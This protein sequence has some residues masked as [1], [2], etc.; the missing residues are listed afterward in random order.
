LLI[1]IIVIRVVELLLQDLPLELLLLILVVVLLLQ[2][3]L[4]LLLNM[5]AEE[6]PINH[7]IIYAFSINCW[8]AS[9]LLL[10]LLHHRP[11]CFDDLKWFLIDIWNHI[12]EVAVI[13]MIASC[14][15]VPELPSWAGLFI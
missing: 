8:D 9:L 15:L 11:I 3:L 5:L 7:L 4:L 2:Q 12:I 10:L 13:I 1:I 6:L 14:I